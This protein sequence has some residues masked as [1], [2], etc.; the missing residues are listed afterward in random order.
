MSIADKVTRIEKQLE[1]LAARRQVVR[2]P[3]EVRR[4]I[5]DDIEDLA[6]PAG[7]SR[8]VFPFN[9]VTVEIL[10]PDAP[11]R[12]AM[13]AV[14]DADGGLAAAIDR[15]LQEA[16]TERPA[17]LDVEV[18]LVR[19][20]GARWEKGKPF[21]LVCERREPTRAVRATEASARCAQAQIVVLTGETTRKQFTLT[22]ERTNIGRLAEVLDRERRVVRRNQ[23]V[24]LDSQHPANQTVSRAQAHILSVPPA[25]FQLF[26]DRS[27]YGTRVFRGGRTIAIPSGSPKGVRLRSGDE[28]YFGQASVRFEIKPG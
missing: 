23:V 8:R 20:A 2:Q 27:S 7:R 22:G 13:T 11:R 18:K 16:G 3:V 1:K 21:R 26:D 28:I 19:A 5:L 6:E 12:A 15:R 17:D 14:L 4:A 24:F 25:G 9:K 10:A